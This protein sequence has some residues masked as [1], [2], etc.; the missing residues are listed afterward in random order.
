[1]TDVLLNLWPVII[2]DGLDG[3]CLDLALSDTR[4]L[5]DL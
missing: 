4:G 5:V 3:L 1:M 2:K